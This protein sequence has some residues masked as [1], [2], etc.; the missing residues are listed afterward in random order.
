MTWLRQGSLVFESSIWN[1]PAKGVIVHVAVS[2]RVL[3]PVPGAPGCDV[4]FP[5]F[6]H[7][8]HP[9]IAD[10]PS[11]CVARVAKSGAFVVPKSG[12]PARC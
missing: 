2:R 11:Q 10:C 6:G 1:V 7:R 12:V 3:F 5:T 8:W 4:K 9:G